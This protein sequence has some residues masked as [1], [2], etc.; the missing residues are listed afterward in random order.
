MIII[1]VPSRTS[2]DCTSTHMFA[3]DVLMLLNTKHSASPIL[4]MKKYSPI[5]CSVP[6][7]IPTP[8]NIDVAVIQDQDRENLNSAS[9]KQN[10]PEKR[11]KLRQ[12]LGQHVIGK[13]DCASRVHY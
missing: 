4:I 9:G 1:Q 8:R 12:W 11:D 6:G 3:Y 5:H 7:H 10:S 13:V 2:D